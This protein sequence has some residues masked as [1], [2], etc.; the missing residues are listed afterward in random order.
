[1]AE[2]TSKKRPAKP[3][4]G[5]IDGKPFSKENQ[6]PPEAKSKGWKERRSEMLLS[7]AIA[8]ALGVTADDQTP[9]KGYAAKLILLAENGNAEALK[10]VRQAIEDEVTKIDITTDGEKV[11]QQ[12]IVLPN[13][14]TIPIG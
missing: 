1:M 10:Q 2:K 12:V 3:F 5:A 4:R 13:G 6:P 7:K 9:L 11:Q 14:A 8:E